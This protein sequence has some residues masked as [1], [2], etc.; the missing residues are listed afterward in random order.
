[1]TT[2][3]QGIAVLVV[4]DHGDWIE[5]ARAALAPFGARILGAG[6]A[7]DARSILSTVTPDVIIADLLLPGDSGLRL[8]QWL[9]HESRLGSSQTPAI[10]VTSLYEQFGREEAEA[11]GFNMFLRKPVD[12]MEL[13]DAV[14]LLIGR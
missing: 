3:L 9:R 13:V 5:F 2:D 12:P 7:D 8:I 6:S 1:M 14:A 4:D 11:G 10:A